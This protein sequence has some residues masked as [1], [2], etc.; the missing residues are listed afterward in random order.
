MADWNAVLADPR[1]IALDNEKKMSVAGKFFDDF[2]AKDERYTALDQRK[3]DSVKKKFYDSA[4]ETLEVQEPGLIR[5]GL[6]R[7]ATV[8]AEEKTKAAEAGE[9]MFV[10]YPRAASKL[11]YEMV[12][13]GDIQQRMTRE[14]AEEAFK[15]KEYGKYARGAAG[16]I[17]KGWASVPE[18]M[19]TAPVVIADM[20][21]K[22]GK[23]IAGSLP[24]GMDRAE[25]AKEVA[26]QTAQDLFGWMEEIVN[27]PIRFA[28]ERPEDVYF[29]LKI[30]QGSVKGTAK[31]IDIAEGVK[32]HKGAKV[33]LREA[34]AEPRVPAK[35]VIE[36]P[37]AKPKPYPTKADIV[38]DPVTEGGFMKVPKVEDIA[39]LAMWAKDN[40]RNAYRSVKEFFIPLSTIKNSEMFLKMRY[41]HLGDLDRL[42]SR[43]LKEHKRLA[44]LGPE[45]NL[46]IF[47]YLDGAIPI[48]KLEGKSR[49]AA[50]NIRKLSD[51]AWDGYLDRGII[52][53]DTHAKH[54]GKYVKYMYLKH[55]LGDKGDIPGT[56]SGKM[57]LSQLKARMDMT[58]EQRRA[59]GWVEDAS[60]AGPVGVAQSWGDMLKYDYL[61][62]ISA[63]PEWTWEPST[64]NIQ[65]NMVNRKGQRIKKRMAIHELAEEVET[66]KRVSEKAPN[67]LEAKQYHKRLLCSDAQ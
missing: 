30:A 56:P 40:A 17:T 25:V 20:L 43:V 61:Q 2:Y 59:I 60:I 27:D 16:N 58:P 66:A 34:F 31:G 63:N 48:E 46:R 15:A 36:K 8:Q 57:D 47:Q 28:F 7:I 11:A 37:I 13:G 10:A 64:V 22:G 35:R 52:D 24:E 50:R 26:G 1:Y 62:K 18:I 21:Y 39:N 4:A 42:E 29:A 19:S 65:T 54:K 51:K 53:L 45:E 3:K 9:P 5:S 12:A 49:Q 23:D 6:E 33:A 44:E 38:P 32:A 14:E 67:N 41:K 55:I